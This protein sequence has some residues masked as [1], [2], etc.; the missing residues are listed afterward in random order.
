MVDVKAHMKQS[1]TKVPAHS[2]SAP[3]TIVGGEYVAP[4]ASHEAQRFILAAR[5]LMYSDGMAT[6][7]K[8]A[9]TGGQYLSDGAVPF[10]SMLIKALEQKIGP[11]N[12]VDM[13]TVVVHLAGSIADLAEKMGD[14]D[15][16]N[17]RAAVQDIVQG[18]MAVISGQVDAMLKAK[19]GA[20]QGPTMQGGMPP[21]QEPDQDEPLM[22][23]A[24]G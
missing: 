12:D 14:P 20:M 16:K 23:T 6:G 13:H 1:G 10:L 9:L 3:G 17:K 15:V 8:H 7:L 11:L 5:A 4:D 22:A 19:Q 2:R 18:V 24:N 21:Q